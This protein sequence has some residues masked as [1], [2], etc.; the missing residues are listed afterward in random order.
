MTDLERA[1]LDAIT[2]EPGL[3]LRE[4]ARRLPYTYNTVA[5]AC[6]RLFAEGLVRR[7][8]RTRATR[9]YP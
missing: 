6:Q 7:E 5:R 9:Y 2:A 1:V 8:G 4:Y 3:H